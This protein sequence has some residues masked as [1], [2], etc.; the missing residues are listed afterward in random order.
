MSRAR[1]SSD[2]RV[3]K[4]RVMVSIERGWARPPIL[5]SSCYTRCFVLAHCASFVEGVPDGAAAGQSVSG[6]GARAGAI[7]EHRQS[8]LGPGGPAWSLAR[9][10]HQMTAEHTRSEWRFP[11][12]Q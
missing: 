7:I 3:R 5:P 9:P 11:G 8:T 1:V 12:W 4:M 6:S 2:A 10:E